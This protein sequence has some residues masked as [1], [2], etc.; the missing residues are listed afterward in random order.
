MARNLSPCNVY[1]LGNIHEPKKFKVH[2]KNVSIVS[3][4]ATQLFL[5]VL[6]TH[7]TYDVERQSFI[8]ISKLREES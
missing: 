1:F 4:F 8:G 5:S 2:A 6:V 3:A 7:K